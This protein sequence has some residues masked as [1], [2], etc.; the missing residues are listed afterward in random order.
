MSVALRLKRFGR[1]HRPFYRLEAI[2]KR[3]ARD[4]KSLETLG[5][6]DPLV[7]EADKRV[8]LKADRIKYWLD[9]GAQPSDTVLSF[10]RKA[11]IKW[12]NPAKK[13]RKAAQ[14][15]KKAAGSK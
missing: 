1:T 2:S 15:V 11:E 5:H 10:L 14:R 12:G 4:G 9:Q 7:A 3:N 13:S 6:Y 8:V